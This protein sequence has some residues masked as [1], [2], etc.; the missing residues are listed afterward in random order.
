MLGP[1]DIEDWTTGEDDRLRAEIRLLPA[2]QAFLRSGARPAD[3]ALAARLS[4][5]CA[6]A[7]LSLCDLESLLEALRAA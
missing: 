6:G 2:V 1:N 7:A 4:R 3:R 5:F